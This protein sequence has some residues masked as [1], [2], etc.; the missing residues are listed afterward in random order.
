M[1]DSD[2]IPC[3]AAGPRHSVLITGCSSGI[4][5]ACALDLAQRG[6]RVFAG[7]R[8]TADG[9]RLR[10]EASGRLEPLIVDV[11]DPEQIRSAA[12][13]VEQAVGEAGLAGLVNNAGIAVP[14]P[15]E[16]LSVAEFRRQ[17]EV[18][19]LGAH[20]VTQR[21]L[22]LLRRAGGRIVMVGSISGRVVAP[23]Y[24]AYAASKHALEALADGLRVELRPWHIAVSIVEPDTVATPIWRK[25][26][27]QLEAL[28]QQ[29]DPLAADRY[30]DDLWRVRRTALR[31]ERAGLDVS[32]AVRAIRHALCA[33]RPKAR[34]PVGLRTRLAI[35]GK[36][37]LP[38]GVMD[39]FL[40]KGVGLRS[41]PAARL[42]P[43]AGP[44]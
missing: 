29:A 21:M 20:A 23:Y 22:P 39:W 36:A 34:Y 25:L 43:G 11:T 9:D 40:R 5:R 4:G 7:V 33:R 14:G 37:L 28:T 2:G 12:A 6:L 17:L 10:G 30:R 42:S 8:R 3:E 15:L 19:V 16:L 13:T 32:A 18:N 24:G 1:V 44:R 35:V 41:A 26:D 38:A 31:M 27:T